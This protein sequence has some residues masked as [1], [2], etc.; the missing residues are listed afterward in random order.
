MCA[1]SAINLLYTKNNKQ[2]HTVVLYSNGLYHL[3]AYAYLLIVTYNASRNVEFSHFCLLRQRGRREGKNNMR[4]K[5]EE[6]M[7]ITEKRRI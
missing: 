7:N 4:S 2:N 1:I 6:F 3:M 5:Q